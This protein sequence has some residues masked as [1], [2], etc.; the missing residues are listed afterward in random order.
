MMV[1]TLAAAAALALS[2]CQLG[3]PIAEHVVLE[4]RAGTF[5][6]VDT[7]N[8]DVV[9]WRGRYLLFF[10]GNQVATDAG[11]WATGVAVADRPQGP[12]RILRQVGDFYN[13]GTARWKGQLWHGASDRNGDPVLLRSRDGVRWS[14]V[15][16]VPQDAAWRAITSDLYLRPS[17]DK[18]RIYFAGRPG[19]AGADIGTA[20]YAEGRWQDFD[21]ALERTDGWDRRDLG[22]PAVFTLGGRN[23]MLYAGLGEDGDARHIGL[24]YRN[25]GAWRRCAGPL[26]SAGGELYRQNAID[27]EPL[28][29]GSR[30]YLFFGGGDRPSLGGNMGGRILVRVYDLSARSAAEPRGGN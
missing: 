6:S 14:A 5:Y 17:T 4:P 29:V 13:G 27:P 9:R 16:P 10:S 28:V 2:P 20:V 7:L 21:M 30:L 23:L 22:E 18:L 15:G 3:V 26:I 12:Y 8:P 24:A 1:A 25:G 11:M 19:A